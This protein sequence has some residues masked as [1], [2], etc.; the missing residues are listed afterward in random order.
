MSTHGE[1]SSGVISSSV[2]TLAS[3]ASQQVF[4]AAPR[5]FLLIQNLHTTNP[6]YVGI[7]FTPT[8]GGG[9]WLTGGGGTGSMIR[10]DGNDIPKD[11]I[12][13]IGTANNAFVAIQA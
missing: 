12:N 3:G 1:N 6:M 9:I 8:V 5:N 11:Q 13:I 4:A 10:L 7:G 2:Q